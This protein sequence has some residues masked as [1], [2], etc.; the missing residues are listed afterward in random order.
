MPD[1]MWMVRAGRKGFLIQDFEEKG[2]VG[3]GWHKLGDL[4]GVK[5]KEDLARMYLEAYP[6]D[7]P[8]K[9]RMNTGQISRFRFRKDRGSNLRLT[10]S[11]KRRAKREADLRGIVDWVD[12]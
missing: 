9:R 4:I 11:Q 6:D 1:T 2:Y 3:V 8:G 12:S 7:K 10:P 5:S